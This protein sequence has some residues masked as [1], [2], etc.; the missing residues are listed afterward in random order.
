MER[1]WGHRM[2]LGA[3]GVVFGRFWAGLRRESAWHKAIDGWF[4]W[5]FESQS[6]RRRKRTRLLIYQDGRNPVTRREGQEVGSVVKSTGRRGLK[7]S[8]DG[9]RLKAHW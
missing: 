1:R 8:L 4:E 7:A 3:N 9:V 6:G 2:D 5:R